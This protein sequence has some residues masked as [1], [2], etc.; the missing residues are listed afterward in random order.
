MSRPD[1]AIRERR[2]EIRERVNER[3]KEFEDAK[4][5]LKGNPELIEAVEALEGELDAIKEALSLDL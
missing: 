3:R 4:Q 1:N 5:K 2:Q